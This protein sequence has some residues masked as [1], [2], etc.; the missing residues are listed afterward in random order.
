M[1]HI[2]VLLL[3]S[4]ETSILFHNSCVNGISTNRHFLSQQ[5]HQHLPFFCDNSHSHRYE[6]IPHTQLAWTCMILMISGV[7][8]ISIWLSPIYMSSLEKMS[9]QLLLLISELGGRRFA[10]Q[11]VSP[12][13]IL[14]INTLPDVSLSNSPPTLQVAFLRFIGCLSCCTETI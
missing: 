6:V 9:V 14:D 7:E 4:Q 2:I 12:M 13:K 1:N 5:P 8:S 11:C 10:I 3:I